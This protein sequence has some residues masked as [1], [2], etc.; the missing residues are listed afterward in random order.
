MHYV[1]NQK[2]EHLA[3]SLF[4]FQTVENAIDIIDDIEEW[5]KDVVGKD[6]NR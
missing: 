5:P 2:Q 6:G 1:A 4:S 3:N